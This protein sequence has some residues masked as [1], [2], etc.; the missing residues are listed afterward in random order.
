MNEE[1][2]KKHPEL[3]KV[4]DTVL[5]VDVGNS[6]V[7][8]NVGLSIPSRISEVNRHG[9]VTAKTSNVIWNGKLYTVGSKNGKANIEPTKYSSDHYKLCLLTAIALSF[10]GKKDISVRL[11]LGL[12]AEFYDIHFQPLKD[13]ILKME[14]QQ[15]TV[16]S[17]EYSIEILDVQVFKQ[18]GTLSSTRAKNYKFPMLMVDLGSV[19]LDVSFWRFV[20]DEFDNKVLNMTA[21]KSYAQYGFQPVMEDLLTRFNSAEG[22]DGNYDIIDAIEFLEEN[23]LPFSTEEELK[24]VKDEI[25]MPYVSDFVSSIKSIFQLSA[26]ESILLMGAPAHILLPY[27]QAEMNVKPEA[28][29]IVIENVKAQHANTVIF[30]E[31]YKEL[32][33]LDY[34]EKV[35]GAE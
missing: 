32:L 10:K 28:T 1:V 13:E 9:S 29:P 12:P 11:A 26:C 19:T 8:T 34:L 20:K 3:K 33:T 18:G 17:V 24:S 15:I 31:R 14:K 22:S 5:A 16:N 6:Y 27:V 2:L 23:Y 30:A 35:K 25:L 4:I 21:A 7:K